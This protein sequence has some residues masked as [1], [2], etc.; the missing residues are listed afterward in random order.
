MASA[1]AASTLGLRLRVQGVRTLALRACQVGVLPGAVV[2]QHDAAFLQQ[3]AQ[4]RH[5]WSSRARRRGRRCG[6]GGAVHRALPR[7][8]RPA[9]ALQT[10]VGSRGH[11]AT[12]GKQVRRS[13]CQAVRL[14]RAGWCRRQP[15][16][17]LQR[18]CASASAASGRRRLLR[19]WLSALLQP[20]RSGCGSS[21]RRTAALH[22]LLWLLGCR[23]LSIA[24]PPPASPAVS[25]A[26]TAGTPGVRLRLLRLLSLLLLRWWLHPPVWLRQRAP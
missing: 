7:R 16:D 21:S 11:V 3:V 4:R 9:H 5:P 20:W 10:L 23:Q 6:A 14:R 17:A 19:G 2:A 1:Q 18:W 15:V 13:V 26:G 8:W 24:R 22:C 25:A 12:G